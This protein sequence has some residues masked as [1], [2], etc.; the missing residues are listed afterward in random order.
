MLRKKDV[1]SKRRGGCSLWASLVV[2]Q[3]A[4]EQPCISVFAC[5]IDYTLVDIVKTRLAK[6]FGTI[7]RCLTCHR[8][9]H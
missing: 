4:E 1:V 7:T 6:V 2:R 5:D 3:N 8:T 9:I